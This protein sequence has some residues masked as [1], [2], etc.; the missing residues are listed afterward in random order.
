MNNDTLKPKIIWQCQCRLILLTLQVKKA[1]PLA[2]VSSNK[3]FSKL[4]LIWLCAFSTLKF[5]LPVI[6]HDVHLL[7]RTSNTIKHREQ[8]KTTQNNLRKFCQL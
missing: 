1:F 6:L 2:G 3:I 5:L 8:H 4:F 7:Q